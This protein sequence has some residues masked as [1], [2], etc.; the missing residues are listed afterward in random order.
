[1]YEADVELHK[2]EKLTRIEIKRGNWYKYWWTLIHANGNILAKQG[3]KGSL[4][5]DECKEQLELCRG[6]LKSVGFAP[7]IVLEEINKEE[8]NE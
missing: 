4:T 7:V 8:Q 6:F 5:I 3:G 2:W 1:M